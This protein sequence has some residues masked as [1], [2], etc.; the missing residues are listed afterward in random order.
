MLDGLE[1]WLLP[2]LN[3]MRDLRG[4]QQVNIAEALSRLLDWQQKQPLDNALPA[5][6]TVPTGSRLPICHHVGKP[7]VLSV[8]LQEV[9]GE[10]RSPMLAEGRIPVVL[11]LLSAAPRR[12]SGRVLTTRCKK[13]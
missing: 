2:S 7:P 5:R 10:Q 3:G 13:R 1:Q 12:H 8:R 4:L 9:F 6:Y 11:E